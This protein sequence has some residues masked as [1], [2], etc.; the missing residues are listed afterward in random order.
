MWHH[1]M[2]TVTVWWMDCVGISNFQPQHS[3]STV[4]SSIVR[5]SNHSWY[6]EMLYTKCRSSLYSS[7]SD[8]TK[9]FWNGPSV[10]TKVWSM[11]SLHCYLLTSHMMN[12]MITYLR[13]YQLLKM[14]KTSTNLWNRSGMPVKSHCSMQK[15]KLEKLIIGSTKLKSKWNRLIY[16]LARHGILSGRVVLDVSYLHQLARCSH[17]WWR[18]KVGFSFPLSVFHI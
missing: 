9:V 8:G 4:L 17:L 18:F 6:A 10:Y 1:G 15:L 11:S 7:W 13:V 14:P 12:R 5:I 16:G 3:T 2:P